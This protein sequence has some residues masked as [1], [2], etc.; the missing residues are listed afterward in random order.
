MV[1]NYE[2]PKG[3]YKTYIGNV[4]GYQTAPTCP[5]C[6]GDLR[7]IGIFTDFTKIKGNDDDKK[8]R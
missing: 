1:D 2:C 3:H 6:G 4:M 7:K 8:N 5:K